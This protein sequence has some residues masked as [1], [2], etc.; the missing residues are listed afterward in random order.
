M[1]TLEIATACLLAL[2]SSAG[3]GSSE[4]NDTHPSTGGTG[5]AAGAAGA[6]GAGGSAAA[7][8]TLEPGEAMELEVTDGKTGT[9]I[10]TPV[11]DEEFVVVLASTELDTSSELYDYSITTDAPAVDATATKLD[12]CTLT[13]D[14]WVGQALPKE[15]PPSGTGPQKGDQK[16][17]SVQLASGAETIDVEAVA[18]GNTAVVWSDVTAAHPATLD[19]AVV[20]EFLT[21][22]EN[23]ILPRARTIFG[24]ESDFDGD[25]HIGLVF[26][27]LTYQTAVAFFTSC[28][29]APSFGCGA[30]NQGEYLYLTPP[31]AIKPPYNTP[32]AI[33]ETLAHELSHMI[34]YNRKVLRN[35]L[36][37]W[38]DSAYMDEGVGG[39]SQD[40]LGYQAG[41]FY[42]TMA[43]L[44]GIDDFSLSDT[45]MDNAVYD[46]QRDGVL[47]GG[48]YLF[49]RW[50]YDHAGGDSVQSDGTLTSKGGPVLLRKLLDSPDTVAT[51]LPVESGSAIADIAMDYWTTLAMSNRAGQ[52]AP[53]N[54][55][56]SYLPTVQDP[57][58]GRTRGADLY[59]S[60]GG[61]TLSGPKVHASADG[62]LR[63]GGG[64][65][66]Q[67]AATPGSSELALSVSADPAAL[68]RVRIVRVH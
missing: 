50:F 33:K 32:N 47:R 43:A 60:F 65:F 38:F 37:A 3:C 57:L 58:T 4:S 18:V 64:E 61:S 53:K 7:P 39:F 52:A 11:G 2:L 55:C 40:V 12:G 62:Q 51:D 20:Q 35:G 56:F 16:Q 63:A 66:V 13:P 27:P 44:D 67:I 10:A 25:G 9:H 45:L 24:V 1:R 17:L 23:I 19:P 42:V 8:V 5:G 14:A 34:H 21:D 41:N 30:G 48:S 28:D 68:P 29:I 54:S 31:N 46:E 22:F 6:A 59:G 36:S 15:T 26:T 49:V